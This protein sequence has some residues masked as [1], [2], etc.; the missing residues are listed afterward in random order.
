M[1]RTAFLYF[2]EAGG[3][4][5]G[6]LNLSKCAGN[7]KIDLPLGSFSYPC[8]HDSKQSLSTPFLPTGWPSQG[9]GDTECANYRWKHPAELVPVPRRICAAG[10]D[11]LNT[12]TKTMNGIIYCVSTLTTMYYYFE[13]QTYKQNCKIKLTQ[14]FTLECMQVQVVFFL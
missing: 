1:S 13:V 3:L 6:C 7:H 11:E 4:R 8:L 5:W 2:P 12:I 10:N 9:T 14:V